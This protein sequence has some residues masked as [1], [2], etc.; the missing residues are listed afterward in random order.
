M[1]GQI[2]KIL[3]Y[4]YKESGQ[5][6]AQNIGQKCLNTFNKYPVSWWES[7]RDDMKFIADTRN[8]IPHTSTLEEAQGENFLSRLFNC[9]NGVSLRCQDLYDAAVKHYLL[10]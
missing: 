3:S 5:T 8:E 1:L 4:E 9:N 10:P 6:F 7:L 2:A